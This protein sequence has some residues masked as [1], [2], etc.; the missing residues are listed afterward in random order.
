M[1]VNSILSKLKD[2][3]NT[4]LVT[5]YVPSAD[6]EMQFRPLSVKQQKDLIKSGLDGTLGGITISNI[7]GDIILTNSVEKYNF[8]VKLKESKDEHRILLTLSN[9]SPIFI[10]NNVVVVSQ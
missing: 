5:I 2:Y 4:N 7:I 8:L 6:K 10:A 1:S 3:N 9:Y